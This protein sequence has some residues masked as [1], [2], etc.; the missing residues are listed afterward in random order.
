M[1]EKLSEPERYFLRAL[2]E[3]GGA[4]RGVR[5]PPLRTEPYELY[6]IDDRARQRCR[7]AGWA[8]PILP[9]SPLWTLTTAGRAAL[10]E[11]RDAE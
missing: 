9:G 1:R 8:V 2:F 10:N 5:P 3:R 11:A 6:R 7:K 4:D